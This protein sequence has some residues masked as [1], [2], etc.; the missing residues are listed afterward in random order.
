[1]GLRTL[2]V[3]VDPVSS[4]I[5]IL[6]HTHISII[7]QGVNQYIRLMRRL[8]LFKKLDHLRLRSNV[9]VGTETQ[10]FSDSNL[11]W[12]SGKKLII[13]HCDDEVIV[14]RELKDQL[15]T[16]AMNL[17]SNPDT[18]IIYISNLDIGS[19]LPKCQ[20]FLF[21]PFI[22]YHGIYWELYK[23]HEPADHN[24][25]TKRFLSLNKRADIFRQLLY[26]K[27]YH[28]GWIADNIFSYL[29]EDR[30]D[31]KR[32]DQDSF[33]YIQSLIA[34]LDNIEHDSGPCCGIQ[35][36][37]DEL[38]DRY[39]R[40]WRK[41][42]PT[43]LVE[44]DWY[45]QTF[46]SVVIETDAGDAFPNLSE[47]TFRSI[48][49]EHPLIL[50]SAPGTVSLLSKMGLDIGPLVMGWESN[51]PNRI[52]HFFNALETING[53]SMDELRQER[54]AMLPQLKVLRRE[55]SKLH[56]Q[57]EGKEIEIYDQIQSKMIEW[58]F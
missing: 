32:F 27:F 10:I 14:S 56:G 11:L 25:V 16:L 45:D 28:R 48:A 31:G 54:V 55:Y 21:I 23:D 19:N 18:H 52:N 3:T 49:M 43:W 22:E 50:F 9:H 34:A 12:S 20:N 1:M 5:G 13:A 44:K 15:P 33:V 6:L 41:V 57:I 46:C 17:D 47:K 29:C 39:A 38:Y 35:I 42:D 37:K 36:E 7:A 40:G 53:K 58:G 24:K 2:I 26:Y 4:C 51:K 30:L 8:N